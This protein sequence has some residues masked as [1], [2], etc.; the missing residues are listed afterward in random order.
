[1]DYATYL[2][3]FTGT[4]STTIEH[5]INSKR[6]KAGF[7]D[8]FLFEYQQVNRIGSSI[9]CYIP[10]FLWL[11]QLTKAHDG[12]MGLVYLPTWEPYKSTIHVG[13][14]NSPMDP[15]TKGLW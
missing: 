2:P 13:R 15:M 11:D 1:M 7:P 8:R 9:R 12:S 6:R 4:I 5:M 10:T 3:P 14:Y